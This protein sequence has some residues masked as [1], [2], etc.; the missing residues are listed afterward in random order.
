[1][2]LL[3]VSLNEDTFATDGTPRQRAVVVVRLVAI[4]SIH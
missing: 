3:G 4:P 1:M 2:R